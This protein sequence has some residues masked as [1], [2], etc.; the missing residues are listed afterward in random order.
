MASN[1]EKL[2]REVR[3]LSSREKAVL[4]RMLIED[5]DP[6]VDENVEEMWIEEAQRRYEAYRA[7]NLKA[8]PGDE[9]IRRARQRLK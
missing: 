1:F 7:G 6:T 5:L 3:A 9:A 2:E 4:T 8:V